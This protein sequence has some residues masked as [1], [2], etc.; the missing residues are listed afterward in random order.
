MTDAA[1]IVRSGAGCHTPEYCAAR[2]AKINERRAALIVEMRFLRD[3]Y[4]VPRVAGKIRSSKKRI[5]EL[6]DEY[7]DLGLSMN[8]WYNGGVD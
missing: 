4:V 3:T 8:R 5:S 6:L 7:R 2:L 1:K